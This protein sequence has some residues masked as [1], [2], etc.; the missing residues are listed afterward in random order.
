MYQTIN[1]FGLREYHWSLIAS[2]IS[3][4]GALFF[5]Y[6]DI[7]IH[8]HLRVSS[9]GHLH[10]TGM[11]RLPQADKHTGVQ[12]PPRN[13]SNASSTQPIEDDENQTVIHSNESS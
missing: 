9:G 8:G 4:F 7:R 10:I 2:M 6:G 12:Y 11:N 1:H 5:L 13:G 3:V